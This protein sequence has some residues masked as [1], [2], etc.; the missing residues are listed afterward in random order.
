MLP[1]SPEC[2]FAFPS[3]RV[4]Y[5]P[6]LGYHSE[7][8]NTDSSACVLSEWKGLSALFLLQVKVRKGNG[9]EMY[10]P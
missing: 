4:M 2:H 10:F 8:S 6:F 7:I 1:E 3:L 9:L 5:K